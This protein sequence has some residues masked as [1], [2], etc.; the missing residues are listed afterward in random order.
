MEEDEAADEDDELSGMSSPLVV[1]ELEADE[2]T[3]LFDLVVEVNGLIW[4]S[5][6]STKGG[7]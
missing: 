6:M 4:R 1:D 3:D 5:L 2:S 7:L